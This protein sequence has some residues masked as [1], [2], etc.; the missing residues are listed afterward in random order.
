VAD[1]L[2]RLPGT[3]RVGWDTEQQQLA[4]VDTSD[5]SE[6]DEEPPANYEPPRKKKVDFVARVRQGHLGL[7]KTNSTRPNVF[8]V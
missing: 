6:S 4:V 8:C 1:P 3:P 7:D 2:V 5:E